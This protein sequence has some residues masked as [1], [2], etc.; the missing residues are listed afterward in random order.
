LPFLEEMKMGNLGEKKYSLRSKVGKTEELLLILV[1]A[2][3]GALVGLGQMA[4]LL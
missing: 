4:F 2:L 3:L 1:G